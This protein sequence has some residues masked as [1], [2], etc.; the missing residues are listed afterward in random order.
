MIGALVAEDL[1]DRAI[2]SDVALEDDEAAGFLDRIVDR[3]DHFLTGR[4]DRVGGFGLEGDAAGGHQIA[5]QLA[6]FDHPLGDQRGSAGFVEIGG[7]EASTRH[8]VADQRRAARDFVEVVDRQ[9]DAR[10]V[11]KREQVQ[12]RIGRATAG[13]HSGDRV[14]ECIAGQDVARLDAR[15]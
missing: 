15:A 11:G 10:F 12:D 13:G 14:F 3:D 1:D 8:H 6:A 9:L 2:R 7:S 4:L 5:A